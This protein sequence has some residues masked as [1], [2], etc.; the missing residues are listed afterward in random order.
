LTPSGGLFG[1]LHTFLYVVEAPETPARVELELP[2]TWAIATSL[3]PTAESGTFLASN[4][5]ELTDSPILAGNLR[6]WISKSIR[7]P[8]V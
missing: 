7:L 6:Q 1:D 2:P 5:F 3:T 8:S 4:A